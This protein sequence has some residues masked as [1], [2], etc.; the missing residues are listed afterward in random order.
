MIRVFCRAEKRLGGATVRVESGERTIHN[1]QSDAVQR[2]RKF[3]KNFFSDL[4][5]CDFENFAAC[6]HAVGGPNHEIIPGTNFSGK[7]FLFEWDSKLGDAIL[8]QFPENI[9]V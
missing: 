7:Y 5:L 4:K 1:N 8:D 6:G 2:S 9:R 3:D